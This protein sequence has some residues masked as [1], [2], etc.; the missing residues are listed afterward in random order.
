MHSVLSVDA[1]EHAHHEVT[2]P[3][4]LSPPYSS[5]LLSHSSSSHP[6]RPRAHFYIPLLS[7][8]SCPIQTALQSSPAS[9]GRPGVLT[10]TR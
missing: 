8:G 5:F 1:C 10:L 9:C 3:H 6:Q 2:P 7:S 4:C